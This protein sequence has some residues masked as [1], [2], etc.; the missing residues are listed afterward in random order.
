MIKKS[1]IIIFLFTSVV[2]MG[3][4]LNHIEKE[5]KHLKDDAIKQQW[6]SIINADQQLREEGKFDAEADIINFYTMVLMEHYH[7]YPSNAK[8]GYPAY[9]TPWVVWVHCPSNALAQYAF[10][11]ILKGRDMQQLPEGRFPDYFVGGLLSQIYGLDMTYDMDFHTNGISPISRF[12]YRLEEQRHE[13]DLSELKKL[14]KKALKLEKQKKQIKVEIGKWE[15]VQ[16]DTKNTFSISLYN[17]RL[18]LKK[19]I[20]GLSDFTLSEIK[21]DENN[22]DRYEFTEGYGHY[23]LV[24]KEGNLLLQD[25]TDTTVK[26][27]KPVKI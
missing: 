2:M 8:Y 24:Q 18:Y 1:I 13:I 6:E 25:H 7:G 27:L 11:I 19:Q 4:N 20:E 17:G 26:T 23:H 12:L 10:P 22:K 5:I 9:T 15:I 16:H 14:A 21:P 3:Q